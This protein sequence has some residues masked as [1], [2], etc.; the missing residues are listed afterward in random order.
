MRYQAPYGSPGGAYDESAGYINGDPS[1]A[2]QGSIPPAAAIEQPMREV[3]AVIKAGDVNPAD[4][5]LMQLLRV[6]RDQ[7]TTLKID[8]GSVNA[9]NTTND[10]IFNPY[11]DTYRGGMVRHVRVA[12]TNTGPMTYNEDGRGNV[13]I[14]R[15]DG[16]D[17][18]PE[19]VPAGAFI[20]IEYDWIINKFQ[21]TS[22]TQ[23]AGWIGLI[24]TEITK[25]VGGVGTDFPTR[26]IGSD[27]QCLRDAV[28]WV[29]RYVITQTGFV[30]FVFVAGVGSSALKISGATVNHPNADRIDF[31]GA[32]GSTQVTVADFYALVVGN[33]GG[34]LATDQANELAMLRT[35]YTTELHV[36]GSAGIYDI[37]GSTWNNLL[38]TSDGSQLPFFFTAVNNVQ[39]GNVS[40]HGAGQNGISFNGSNNGVSPGK[41]LTA[42]GCGVGASLGD[43]I[44]IYGV[45]YNDGSLIACSNVTH[46][47]LI[48]GGSVFRGTDCIGILTS[49][50][51]Q[52]GLRMRRAF[53][54][55]TSATY[56]EKNGLAG[57]SAQGSLGIFEGAQLLA[58]GGPGCDVDFGCNIDLA[59]A[60]ITGNTTA[61]VRAD[62]GSNVSI[63]S[64]TGYS[65]L[66]PAANTVGNHNSLISTT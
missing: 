51:T 14:V 62:H 43:G 39:M 21:L 57:L 7:V 36:Q 34:Q 37:T 65:T 38:I 22:V 11:L 28:Y 15:P 27:D 26:L 2:R 6:V 53:C 56:F 18:S 13:P 45:F 35:K 50:N 12:H 33:S 20:D 54:E 3:V 8:T 9:I 29:S 19:E 63:V 48:D 47:I 30:H 25:T 61:D 64:A 52:Y 16:K 32:P 5:D 40:I 58:N 31:N 66:S 41:V 24:D 59:S 60:Y 17:L 1:V 55:S 49:G 23:T 46:G 42:S 10:G 44:L 4:N